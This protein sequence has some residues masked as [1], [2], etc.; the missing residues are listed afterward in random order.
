MAYTVGWSI[1]GHLLDFL[2]IPCS[3][4]YE[5]EH[6]RDGYDPV[7]CGAVG[8]DIDYGGDYEAYKK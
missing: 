6:S 5:D 7:K 4:S 8:E 2:G 3:K 1:L